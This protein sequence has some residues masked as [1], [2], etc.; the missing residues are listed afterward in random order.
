MVHRALGAGHEMTVFARGKGLDEIIAAGARGFANYRTVAADCEILALCLFSDAQVR[1]VLFE[2][3]ALAAM[4]PSSILAIHTTGSP[5]LA[6]EIGERAPAG[7]AVIDA[8]F[9]GGPHTVLA[10]EL[11]AMVGGDPDAVKRARPL[12]AS[13]ARAI[14]SVGPLGNGQMVKLLNNLLFATNLRNTAA[15]LEI[16]EAQGFAVA[17]MVPILKGCSGD[18][19][20]LN[21]FA[22]GGPG[23]TLARSWPFVSKDVATVAAGAAEAGLDLATF[24]PIIDFFAKTPGLSDV[25]APLGS[26]KR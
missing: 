3:G 24:A 18:S 17:D 1:S 23:E 15:L 10:G 6:R 12:I 14:H 16:A 25:F 5:A 7:V 21:L 22:R 13:Y 2:E 20:A 26:G 8:T 19:F 11:T 9:S 4:Q